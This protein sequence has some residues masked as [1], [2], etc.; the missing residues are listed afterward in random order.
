VENLA[1]DVYEKWSF[2][3]DSERKQIKEF[4]K[5]A[6]SRLEEDDRELP[7]V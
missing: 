4:V 1:N 3:G 6:L 5:K 7:Q 2:I